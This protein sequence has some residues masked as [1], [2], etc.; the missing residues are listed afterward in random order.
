MEKLD[1]TH[2]EQ[3]VLIPEFNSYCASRGW[4]FMIQGNNG[5][6]LLS[7]LHQK[8]DATTG[9]LKS[10]GT[11]RLYKDH[12]YKTE[13]FGEVGGM[14]QFVVTE[15]ASKD[16]VFELET[17]RSRVRFLEKSLRRKEIWM[18]GLILAGI[19]LLM[20]WRFTTPP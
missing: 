13:F 19:I 1:T 5:T 15:L 10:F 9:F 3:E 20:V 12:V 18:T 6:V 16:I 17:S 8:H 4:P 14:E 2:F 11:Y 7:I